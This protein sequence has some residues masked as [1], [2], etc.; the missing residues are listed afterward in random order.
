MWEASLRTGHIGHGG[1]AHASGV[2]AFG[3]RHCLAPKPV[4]GFLGLGTGLV[5]VHGLLV[6]TVNVWL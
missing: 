6:E 5:E 3:D 4:Q 1:P 2:H